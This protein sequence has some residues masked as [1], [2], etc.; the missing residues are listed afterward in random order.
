MKAT[1]RIVTTMAAAV[2]L[3]LWLLF[4]SSDATS[5]APGLPLCPRNK[6]LVLLGDSIFEAFQVRHARTV[7]HGVSGELSHQILKRVPQAV[8]GHRNTCVVIL[9]GTNDVARGH[10]R[11]DVTVENVLQMAA[12]VQK[13]GNVPV[14]VSVLPV[15]QYPWNPGQRPPP[16][17][18]IVALNRRLRAGVA[19][20][21]DVHAAFA[22]HYDEAFVDNVHPS[23]KGYERLERLLLH[24]VSTAPP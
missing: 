17:D 8:A 2:L 14:V 12:L 23:A 7:N 1:T 20:F 11:E 18:T 13:S 10:Y 21:V 9:A 5:E 3:L 15:R 24:F 22:E 19:H 6:P 16:W 4:V